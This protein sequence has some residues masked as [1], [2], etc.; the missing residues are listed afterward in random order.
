VEGRSVEST[1]RPSRESA[2]WWQMR[3]GVQDPLLDHLKLAA[4]G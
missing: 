2:E 3:R 1:G 4:A